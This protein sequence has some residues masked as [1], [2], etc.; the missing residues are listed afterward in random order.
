MEPYQYPYRSKERGGVWNSVAINYNSL[1]HPRFK[2]TKRS[3]RDRP[4]LLISK[5]K[6]KY[7]KKKMPLVFLA[8]SQS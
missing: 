4:T 2:V 6:A 3:V 1:D 8:R 7:G 5:Y